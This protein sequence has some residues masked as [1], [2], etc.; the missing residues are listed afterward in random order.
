VI[1]YE[2][3]KI[4]NRNSRH[5]KYNSDCQ[6]VTVINAYYLLTGKIIEQ[7]SERYNELCELAR[8]CYGSAICIEKVLEELNLEVFDESFSIPDDIDHPVECSVW[9]KR[10]GYHSVLIYDHE[11]KCNAYRV[12][13]LRWLTT[14]DGW[15]FNEDLHQIMT[16][17]PQRKWRTRKFR[18]K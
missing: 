7:G 18:I 17:I 2:H 3:K 15:I 1:D 12:S 6:V 4:I 11:P 14:H 13:G 9:Y 10:C 16:A 8:A 5:E